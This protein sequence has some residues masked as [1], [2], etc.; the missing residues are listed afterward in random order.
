MILLLL[1]KFN[2]YVL[3]L[4]AI[5]IGTPKT[6]QKVCLIRAVHIAQDRTH[7]LFIINY[8]FIKKFLEGFE[9]LKHLV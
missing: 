1:M 9:I 2:Y 5:C 6:N 8:K 3:I 7:I 4:T